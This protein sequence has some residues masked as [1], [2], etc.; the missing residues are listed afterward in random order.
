MARIR[1][2]DIAEGCGCSVAVASRVIN[3][4]AGNSECRPELRA[5]ILRRAAE[6]GY[7]PRRSPRSARS[8]SSGSV[9]VCLFPSPASTLAGSYES[10][11]LAGVE[12]V[13]RARG[14]DL[15]LVG[16]RDGAECALACES[17][18]ASRRVD[19]AVLLRVP[20]R[21]PHAAA[22][23]APDRNAVAVNYFGP[24]PID[25]VNFDG[26]A[27][28]FLAVREL[29]RAGHRRIGYVGALGPA[30]GAGAV[31]RLDGFLGAMAELRLSADPRWVFEPA[32]PE[33]PPLGAARLPPAEAARRAA[34]R[35]A[36]APA[37]TR[38]TAFAAYSDFYALLFLAEL[39]RLGLECPRDASLVGLDDD[40]LCTAVQPALSTVRQPL[41][42]MGGLAAERVLE[43]F[44]ESLRAG[45]AVPAGGGF[46]GSGPL[47]SAAARR[48]ARGRPPAAVRA[49]LDAESDARS[50]RAA[51]AR[52]RAAPAPRPRWLHW[53][54]PVFV[55]RESV[56][57]LA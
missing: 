22:L 44:A 4:S 35:F 18:L 13:A 16:G 43:R 36:A 46:A 20:D 53:A 17:R 1:L 55:P 12:R 3:G 15:L 11:L 25:A 30:A 50:A 10:R 2:Q 49:A 38:P 41:E 7:A 14:R 6:A 39:R 24:E 9:G 37:Q 8:R 19:G 23:A 32:C 57:S 48:G 5:R 47:A 56:R 21:S 28:T 29:F 54:K 45:D 51:A 31:R 33:A 42:E 40:P 26:R 27:A 34:R 52:R